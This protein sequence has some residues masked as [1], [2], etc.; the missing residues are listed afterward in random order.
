M[1]FDG[2]INRVDHVERATG[3]AA[4]IDVPRFDVE[5]KEFGGQA[6][7]FHAFDVGA[8]GCWWS[9]AQIEVVVSHRRGYVIMRVDD[10]GASLD[11]LGALPE[12]LI[13]RLGGNRYCD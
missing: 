13:A 2:A 7:F 5:R 12:T 1:A 9:S 11:L 6:A 4:V 10:D 8:V 3:G